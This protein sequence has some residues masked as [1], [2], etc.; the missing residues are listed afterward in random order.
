MNRTS[1]SDTKRGNTGFEDRD[2]KSP[3][4]QDIP[5]PR[6]AIFAG[7]GLIMASP[8]LALAPQQ[9]LARGE[10]WQCDTVAKNTWLGNQRVT[11][12]GVPFDLSVNFKSAT[13]NTSDDSWTVVFQLYKKVSKPWSGGD[14][15]WYNVHLLIYNNGVEI[16]NFGPGDSQ[17]VGNY[18]SVIHYSGDLTVRVPEGGFV[19]ITSQNRRYYD[20]IVSVG[21]TGFD[22]YITAPTYYDVWFKPGYGSNETIKHQ[23]VIKG[24]DATAPA[25]PSRDGY[26][27]KGWDKS[28]TNV[29]S[30][31]TVTAK[32]EADS[33]V[34]F[35]SDGEKKYSMTKLTPGSTLTIPQEAVTACTK[36][37]CTPGWSG[38]YTDAAC[39]QAYTP[40]EVP[41]GTLNLYSY[42]RLTVKFALADGSS[43]PDGTFTT[44]PGGSGVSFELVPSDRV[45]KWKSSLTLTTPTV[46]F[47][48]E[49]NGKYSRW[50]PS[51]FY[52]DAAGTSKSPSP[53]TA[54]RDTTLYIRW[55]KSVAE[56]ASASRR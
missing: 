1:E 30:D 55:K 34:N 15:V 2:D 39:T 16:G 47:K 19:H 20:G 18:S 38:W 31:L 24:G 56:G 9:A 23:V 22:F 36:E 49:G 29:Q 51:G 13:R 40:G 35:Y 53:F 3:R 4:P 12:S 37:G 26:T 52:L 5:F 54:T 14:R 28:Y 8:L 32:W 50:R 7:L 33:N 25:N 43:T 44:T 6:R 21:T 27:F 10:W 42:N 46:C 48:D 17:E 11:L 41:A 45:V